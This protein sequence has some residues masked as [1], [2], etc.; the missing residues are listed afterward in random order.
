MPSG[1]KP[2]INFPQ[3]DSRRIQLPNFRGPEGLGSW[4]VVCPRQ[5][6][7][8]Y[9]S[10]DPSARADRD[11]LFPI[12]AVFVGCQAI[13]G[14]GCSAWPVFMNDCLARCAI[15]LDGAWVMED[16]DFNTSL[17]FNWAI[18]QAS[19]SV[20]SPPLR[21]GTILFSKT[22]VSTGGQVIGM[23]GL[24]VAVNAPLCNQ[25]ELW[26]SI[27]KN[28]GLPTPAMSMSLQFAV[29]RLGG[30]YSA[31]VGESSGGGE[32]PEANAPVP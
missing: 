17:Q 7:P 26:G 21:S 18:K 20:S 5:P 9:D 19:A 13:R 4:R 29:D 10:A 16:Y 24:I 22:D 12:Q 14:A 2:F 27:Q 28:Q 8:V 11:G 31:F 6:V 23:L 15:T 3:G 32:L 30:D 1:N 25:F